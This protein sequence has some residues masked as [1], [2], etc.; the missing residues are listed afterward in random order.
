MC[1]CLFEFKKD[2]IFFPPNFQDQM[3]EKNK[4]KAT[5]KKTFGMT[6]KE[7]QQWNRK[8]RHSKR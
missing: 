4:E 7:S 6:Y 8:K 1:Q 2:I 5:G 3:M